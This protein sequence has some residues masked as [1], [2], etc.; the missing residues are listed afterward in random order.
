MPPLIIES[1]YRPGAIGRIT[2]MHATWYAKAHGFGAVFESKVAAGLDE[3][4]ERLDH[5]RNGLWLAI[6]ENR[7]VGSVAIDGQDQPDGAAHLRYF[8]V[9]EDVRGTG[10]GRLLL[11]Q[12]MSFVDAQGFTKTRLWTF[13]GLDAARHLYEAEGFTL[14]KSWL[15][16]QWGREVLEQIFERVA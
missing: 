12:A 4:V 15:G 5:G 9:D 14:T 1:G 6:V 10:A 2:E 3:W 8:I 11:R 16:D 13:Q 7:V